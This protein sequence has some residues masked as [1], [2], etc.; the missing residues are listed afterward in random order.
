MQDISDQIGGVPLR[1]IG[2]PGTHDSA[3]YYL[4]DDYDYAKTQTGDFTSQ[5]NAGARWLDFRYLYLNNAK[6]ST[7]TTGSETLLLTPHTGWYMFGHYNRCTN[8]LVTDAFRQ[9]ASF[10]Q[11]HPQEIIIVTEGTSGIP[12]AN[13]IAAFEQSVAQVL[14]NPVNGQTYIY[15]DQIACTLG[16]GEWQSNNT[17]DDPLAPIAPQNV[18]PNQLWSTSARVILLH[19][20]PAMEGP[21]LG[22]WDKSSVEDQAG[23]Y[24]PTSGT[25]NQSIELQWLEIGTPDGK[26]GLYQEHP[27]YANWTTDPKMQ[28][29]SAEMTPFGSGPFTQ[30]GQSENAYGYFFFTPPIGQALAF[31]PIL[32]GVIQNNLAGWEKNILLAGLGPT[33]ENWT[34]YDVNIVEMDCISCSTG[35]PAAVI[36]INDQQWPALNSGVNGTSDLAYGGGVTYRLET[37]TLPGNDPE[38]DRWYDASQSWAQVVL[39]GFAA[40]TGVRV[41]VDPTGNPWVVSSA[42][43]ISRQ[44]SPGN[45]TP[46]SGLSAAD[47][48]IGSQGSVWAIGKADSLVY[49][50]NQANA[51]WAQQPGVTATHI[52]VDNNGQPW[53][54]TS[55]DTISHFNGTWNT[56]SAPFA[57]TNIAIGPGNAVWTLG[58]N[59]WEY[60]NSTWTE[61]RN[62]GV[63]LSV[64]YAGA[65]W[66]ADGQG[67]LFKGKFRGNLPDPLPFEITQSSCT[68]PSG[69]VQCILTV[70][71]HTQTTQSGPF[72][73]L[74]IALTQGTQLASGLPYH[75]FPGVS[76]P[77]TSL[78]PGESTVL[79]VSFISTNPSNPLSGTSIYFNPLVFPANK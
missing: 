12:D 24:D 61:Y 60:N 14:T 32:T 21:T 22:S 50:Y 23:Y 46:V 59:V 47:I 1:G 17:C 8:I 41:A 56:I 26:P 2:M 55:S 4:M 5:L 7:V 19:D 75:G 62:A 13:T 30:G 57:P 33:Q 65:P 37:G 15:N 71:N 63:A 3:M 79:T 28:Y 49:F 18:T 76:L 29:L 70:T 66:V 51:M 36:G 43:Q 77:V 35:T 42:G 53:V 40:Q 31:D 68:N 38:L 48:G 73:L 54:I 6:C 34:P 11:A 69:T 52:A 72:V 67:G 74:P 20:N 45:W 44:V 9:I 64:D 25:S 16:N 78:T 39:S 10:L 58:P 27:A